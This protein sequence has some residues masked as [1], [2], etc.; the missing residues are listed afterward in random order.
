MLCVI[1]ESL[2][3]WDPLG[4]NRQICIQS[5]PRLG[6]FHHQDPAILLHGQVPQHSPYFS[7][8]QQYSASHLRIC[9]SSLSAMTSWGIPSGHS[10]LCI[11][12]EPLL[13]RDAPG[14]SVELCQ[15]L[16]LSVQNALG[17]VNGE[18]TRELAKIGSTEF[19]VVVTYVRWPIFFLLSCQWSTVRFSIPQKWRPNVI[20]LEGFSLRLRMAALSIS[21]VS[22]PFP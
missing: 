22:M 7:K 5:I 19:R 17:E 10:V 20:G 4:G 13:R 3:S 11:V 8:P 1:S 16:I 18:I 2:V 9:Y 12:G 15:D 21:V 6:E 14:E